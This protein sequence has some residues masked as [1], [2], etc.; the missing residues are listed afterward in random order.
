MM[1][2]FKKKSLNLDTLDEE[3]EE[4]NVVIN[5]YAVRKCGYGFV[6]EDFGKKSFLEKNILKLKG[7]K[8]LY[9]TI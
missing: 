9:L 8:E 6:V 4:E 1:V 2:I 3:E 7:Q 5:G